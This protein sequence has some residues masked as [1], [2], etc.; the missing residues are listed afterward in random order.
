[1]KI[2]GNIFSIITFSFIALFILFLPAV[3]RAQESPMSRRWEG[4]AA[5]STEGE[6]PSMGYYGAS[7]AFP[8]NSIVRVTNQENGNSIKLVVVKEL[9]DSN[10]FIVVSEEAG[11]ELS[12]GKKEAVKVSVTPVSVSGWGAVS[13]TEDLPYHPDPDINP[14]AGAGDPNRGVLKGN[15]PL[16]PEEDVPGKP[17]LAEEAPVKTKQNSAEITDPQ[18]PDNL[19]GLSGLGFESAN[20]PPASPLEDETEAV[21]QISGEKNIMEEPETVITEDTE[22]D[23]APPVA[24]EEPLL[25]SVP[26]EKRIEAPKYGSK[27]TPEDFTEARTE[28]PAVPDEEPKAEKPLLGESA[29]TETLPEQPVFGEAVRKPE[30][31]ESFRGEIEEEETPQ[32]SILPPK[33]PE[34]E[35]A[36]EETIP[37]EAAPDAALLEPDSLTLI[38]PEKEEEAVAALREPDTPEEAVTPE[39]PETKPEV[40]E[41]EPS[42]YAE[43]A[44]VDWL[45]QS[46]ARAK[47]RGEA[48]ET[49]PPP[50]EEKVFELISPPSRVERFIIDEEALS[51]AT[52]PKD[53]APEAGLAVKR[54][55]EE[56]ADARLTEAELPEER[57][58][59]KE[60]EAVE[61]EPAEV[62][63]APEKPEQA[64]LNYLEPLR[65]AAEQFSVELSEAIPEAEEEISVTDIQRL[66]T[67]AEDLI[68]SLDEA[69]P[70]TEEKRPDG[71]M[72]TDLRRLKAE[73]E[74]LV[75]Q[76]VEAV[77][78]K[79]KIEKE[80]P[81]AEEPVLS[82]LE[83]LRTGRE[84][85]DEELAEA[86]PK[87]V[88]EEEEQPVLTDIRRLKEQAEDIVA[89]LIEVIP[90]EQEEEKLDIVK[91]A[92]K[93][94]EAEI[95]QVEP[96]VSISES[97]VKEDDFPIKPVPEDA[98]ISLEPAEHRPPE[99]P[100]PDASEEM[101]YERPKEAEEEP[102]KVAMEEPEALKEEPES[103]AVA[104]AEPDTEV[105]E[106]A[107]KDI[108]RELEQ[109]VADQGEEAPEPE[110]PVVHELD[111]P[112]VKSLRKGTYYLQVGVYSNPQIARNTLDSMQKGFPTAVTTASSAGK[113]VFK[114]LV[115]PLS[116]DEQ[117]SV[118]YWLRSKGYRDAFAKH[119][120]D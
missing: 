16:E 67:A 86:K 11:T 73:A 80:E 17:E 79:P 90:R 109:I 61:E 114:V 41:P 28:K 60:I 81:P 36:T 66:K 5:V 98:E 46:L 26:S 35:T 24:E 1:M 97:A 21:P 58:E 91:P 103:E 117:G 107:V 31:E 87:D 25:G 83:H 18:K 52:P 111:L 106:E 96:E 54:P 29:P 23:E 34:V 48:K 13:P 94:E 69:I 119:V 33:E 56:P 3:S 59:E 120:T 12:I 115:G 112:I 55:E 71:P 99:I 22:E 100:E 64:S 101:V 118:L 42:L 19:E 75:T 30:T 47:R 65:K 77:P 2:I 105:S 9:N 51:E 40:T 102:E 8:R 88:E 14:S 37:E 7:D 62:V 49:F 72:V 116:E 43:A 10:L 110:K 15:G 84:E 20:V 63:E 50:R 70:K 32:V 6:F 92:E 82:D 95:A 4:L 89:E 53:D 113:Q 74:E 78:G 104:D 39:E 45:E 85:I 93:E 27:V 44:E 76:L 108:L 68:V 38:Q 57:E